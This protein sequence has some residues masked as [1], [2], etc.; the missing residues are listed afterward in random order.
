VLDARP[1]VPPVP[2]QAL[3]R[4]LAHVLH[5]APLLDAGPSDDDVAVT[6]VSLDSRSVQPG[7]LYAALP[8]AHTHG[9][10]YAAEAASR[11]AAAALTDLA[12]A[13]EVAAAGLPALVVDDP[14]SVLGALA[15]E[16]Y[17]HPDERL[18]LIGVTGTNGK[19]TTAYLVD[20]GLRAAGRV[21]G[22]L[23]TV[24][25]HV[26]G[27]V[28]PS[29]RTTPEAPEV[30]A[31]L[32]LMVERGCDA[33]SMEVSSHALA[34]GRVDG[35]TYDVAVFT[36]L[37]QDHLDFHPSMADYFAAKAQLFTPARS[38]H[39]VIDIDDNWGR[40][41]AAESSVPVS[42]VSPSGSL[43]AHWRAEDVR[44]TPLGSSFRAVGPGG[45][46]VE[47]GVRLPG[48]FNV[49]NALLAIVALEV[50]GVPLDAA[51]SGVAA[52]PGV[53]GRMET[54]DA[55]QGFLAVVDYAH[56]PD[57]VRRL[58][59]TVRQVTPGQVVIVLGCGG[60]RDPYKRPLMGHVAAELADVAVLTSDNPRSEDPG[61]IIAA[62]LDGAR[63]GK[64]E[65]FVEADRARAIDIAVA[66]ANPGDAVV[67]A[68]KGHE[69]GQEVAGV[70]RPFDDRVV[71][72]ERLTALV[73]GGR[74]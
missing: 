36:N 19:T 47:A 33:A 59:E 64:G 66:R 27:Q 61:A 67:V 73:S 40:R 2:L 18:L 72:R 5:S 49:A 6:G 1:V 51:A 25:T 41:L 56:T 65:V 32:A 28:M 21:T 10:R 71:L 37:T 13:A 50:A 48:M 57:A 30:Q 7:D 38:R 34:L 74:R 58:L 42:R 43:G 23:G 31:L 16:V 12:G 4:A 35:T 62:M 54:V 22:L 15:A 14:R 60:D 29:V 53:P 39:G 26:A 44:L 55:G 70:V 52:L 24:E 63:A 45:R 17:A 69:Q 3:S 9:A 68:G 11:G 20:A 8:G 46:E